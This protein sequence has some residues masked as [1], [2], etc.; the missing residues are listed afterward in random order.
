MTTKLRQSRTITRKELDIL[1]QEG[2]GPTLEFK[3]NL[4]PSFARGM[5]AFANTVGGRA[6][7]RGQT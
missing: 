2:E 5:V 6:A 4:S 3:E 1:I 7:K